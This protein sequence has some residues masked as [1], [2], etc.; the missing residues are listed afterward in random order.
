MPRV[1]RGTVRRAKRKRLLSRAKGY[2][3]NKSKLYRAAKEAVDKALG[4]AFVG[5]RLPKSVSGALACL[6]LGQLQ[7]PGVQVAI[8]HHLAMRGVGLQHRLAIHPGA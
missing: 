5:R 6:A 7:T 3:L 4:Y 2:Y 8:G 1:K